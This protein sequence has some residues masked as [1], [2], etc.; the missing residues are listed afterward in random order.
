M[1]MVIGADAANATRRAAR[2]GVFPIVAEWAKC[3]ISG[4]VADASHFASPRV[5]PWSTGPIRLIRNSRLCRLFLFQ[6]RHSPDRRRKKSVSSCSQAPL[7]DAASEAPLR[8]SEPELRQLELR[9]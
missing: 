1:V 3:L 7:G 6:Y 9:G 8:E 2:T 4:D 5:P